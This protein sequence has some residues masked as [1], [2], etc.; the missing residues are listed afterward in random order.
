MGLTVTLV[1]TLS[2][3]LISLLRHLI[4]ARV[5]IPCL[6]VIIASCTTI[7]DY[8]LRAYRIDVYQRLGVF[9]PLIAVSCFLLYRGEALAYRSK[10][11]LAIADGL[12]YG[13]GFMGALAILGTVREIFG[14]GTFL[15][16]AVLPPEFPVS[17]VMLQP[18]GA[19]ITLGLL[20]G[21]VNLLS[22]VS[23]LVK[24]RRG[25]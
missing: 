15:D 24:S 7:A 1:L 20:I 10:P 23:M 25:T 16:T 17:A 12:G 8:M 3:L 22:R 9:I 14:A 6:M 5:R 19:F 13:L 4:P 18:P 21:F 2:N 11:S